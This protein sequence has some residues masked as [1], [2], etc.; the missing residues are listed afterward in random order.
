ML[1][2]LSKLNRKGL[3]GGSS[4]IERNEKGLSEI[5]EKRKKLLVY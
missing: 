2:I 4:V 3:E 1:S 5:K